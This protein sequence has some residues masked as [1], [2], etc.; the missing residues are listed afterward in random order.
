MMQLLT[1][2]PANIKDLPDLTR[3]WHEK[4]I[5]QQQFDRHFTLMRDAKVVWAVAV[6]EWITNSACSVQI[7]SQADIVVGYAIGW[8]RP[9]PPGISPSHIGWI[10]EMVV[11]A[12]SPH[13]GVGKSL[14]AAL[15]E[16]FR[17]REIQN[18]IAAVPR[19]SAVEQAFW[20]AQGAV[21]WVDLM[22]IK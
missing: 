2:R 14:L 22:W 9:G 15:K 21:E 6:A 5:L 12:H 17:E 1:V 16:W 18:V 4:M 7:A 11:D 20:L 3:L 13:G 10:E 19:L 8:I